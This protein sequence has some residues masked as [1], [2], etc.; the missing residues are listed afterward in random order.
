MYQRWS[1][2]LFLHWKWDP[3]DLQSCLPAG[4]H[5]DTFDVYNEVELSKH[6]PDLVY[7]DTQNRITRRGHKIPVQAA[8]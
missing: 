4:L 3:E 1:D 6:E 5:I 7:V 8:A 2:L